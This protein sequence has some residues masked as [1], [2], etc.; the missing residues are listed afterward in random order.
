MNAPRQ[1]GL[2]SRLAW[3]WA[4]AVALALGW[5]PSSGWTD[6]A[7]VSLLAVALWRR[8]EALWRAWGGARGWPAGA[9]AAWMAATVAWSFWPAGSARDLAKLLPLGAG[10]VGLAAWT[11]TGR[12]MRRALWLWASVV[13]VRLAADGV[14]LWAERG[15]ATV[16][17]EGRYAVDFLWTH[18]NVASVAGCLAAMV[19]VGLLPRAG[20]GWR[21]RQGR[22]WARWGSLAA[23]AVCLGY[24]LVLGSRGPQAVFA[25]VVLAWPAA[26]ARGWR[27]KAVAVLLAAA[28]GAGLWMAAARVNPRFGDTRTM[29]GANRRSDIWSHAW[30][31][32]KQRPLVGWGYGKKAF[33]RLV[34][35]NPG[36]RAP[37][38]PVRF[39][40]AHSHWLMLFVE[41]G[42]IGAGLGLAAWA[43][44]LAGVWKG[45]PKQIEHLE[46]LEYFA[47][48]PSPV[49]RAER[50]LATLMVLFVLGY[51]V[52]DFPDNGARTALWLL[53]GICAGIAGGTT[54]GRT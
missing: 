53:G 38:V 25:L 36:Q 39:P 3:A 9:L 5:S 47:P 27:R 45:R 44:L 30:M 14:R 18:P 28:V 42:A 2:P 24:V 54:G 12:E 15:W 49:P 8:R 7:L 23:A 46:H 41:G 10:M 29:S 33:E 11:G 13:T 16:F 26:L 37:D 31:L 51:G 22:G 20:T 6:A 32:A 34:Y 19:W 4:A 1:P 52:A 48:P 17:R 21:F 43:A 35:E 40:H 50:V